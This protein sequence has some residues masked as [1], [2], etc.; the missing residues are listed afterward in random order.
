[1][2]T[3]RNQQI[4]QPAP[5]AFLSYTRFDDQHD[6]GAI[7]AF[8]LRLA[9]AVRAVTGQPFEIF[10]DVD[11]I[12]LGEKWSDKLDQILD[13]ARFFMP[14]I[15]PTY[16]TSAACREELEKF[17]QA[18][19]RR[20]RAD[21]V[22]PIYYIECEILEDPA[23]RAADSLA[24]AIHERQR[25][26]WR[27]LRFEPVDAK[28]VRLARER[29]AREI[30]RVR[31][32]ALPQAPARTPTDGERPALRHEPGTVF[33]DIDAP[34]CPELVV[35]PRGR[36]AMGSPGDAHSRYADERPQHEVRI[37]YDLAVGRYPVTF[38][39]YDR[40]AEAGGAD[41]SRDEG[42]GRGRRPVINVSWKEAKAY[43]AWLGEETGHAYRL[44][45]EAEWEYACRAGTTSR[46]WWG[47]DPPTPARAAFDMDRSTEVG[48][49]PPNPWGLYDMHGNVWDWV[50]D[51]WNDSYAGAPDD[52]SAWTSGDCSRRVLRGGSWGDRGDALCS[53]GRNRYL[54]ALQYLNIGFRVARTLR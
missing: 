43:V 8:R 39:E 21:L 45:S 37:A 38:E 29:L 6:G 2:A 50:E 18:E 34:W 15:T 46:Y 13:Q 11:G 9:D 12:G 48:A 7:S 44:L 47:D 42:W 26:D 35:L 22:L 30:S 32:R 41:L 33:R 10:Q 31:R 1:M 36:F 5:D 49:Y 14:I 27:V 20:G 53:S 28:D 19:A 54:T 4:V 16:F 51:C 17:L 25:Q 52:G 24:S 23:L 3:T 40:F